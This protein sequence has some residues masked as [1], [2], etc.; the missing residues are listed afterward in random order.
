MLSIESF[1]FSAD[2]SQIIMVSETLI[3]TAERKCYLNDRQ[4]LAFGNKAEMQA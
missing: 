3:S 1:S 2:A 4:C